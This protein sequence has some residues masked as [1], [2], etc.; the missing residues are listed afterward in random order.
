MRQKWWNQIG[1]GPL[2]AAAFIG[3]GTV[4]ACTLAGVQFGYALLWAMVFSVVAT[5][6]LQ[7]MAVR[8]GIVTQRGFP[9]SLNHR[10]LIHGPEN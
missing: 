3:P 2:I 9:M 10:F 7:E 4:T 5:M 8:L 6:V 1:P